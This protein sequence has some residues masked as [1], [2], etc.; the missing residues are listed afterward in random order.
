[1]IDRIVVPLDGSPLAERIIPRVLNV[2]PSSGLELNLLV[3]VDM[4]GTVEKA[5]VP[6]TC[7]AHGAREYL[8][9]LAEK[10]TERGVR[11][12]SDI[13]FGKAAEKILEHAGEMHASLIAMSTHGRTGLGR[14]IRGSVAEAVLREANV[15]VFMARG[16]RAQEGPMAST[17]AE[18]RI[19][20]PL[21]GSAGSES[22]LPYVRCLALRS[23]ATVEILRVAEWSPPSEFAPHVHAESKAWTARA[24]AYVKS[25]AEQ[26]RAEGINVDPIVAHGA[27]AEL[28]L[29]HVESGKIH[30]VAMSTHGYSGVKRLVFG[31]VAEE[32]LR[33][34]TVPL[35][36]MREYIPT[37]EGSWANCADTTPD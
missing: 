21:D 6:V 22:V 30:L 28:I 15:P 29:E 27:P 3:V 35:L 5:R 12:S 37:H 36:A 9:A 17:P 19:L 18:L 1:M 32:V 2:F 34:I 26:L 24:E 8:E 33:R 11:V 4:E 14:V 20:V 23:H 16:A 31:S 13:R 10:V 25:V 7:S